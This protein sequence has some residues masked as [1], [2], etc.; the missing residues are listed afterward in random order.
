ME[1]AR[2]YCFEALDIMTR[3]HDKAVFGL[4]AKETGQF[5]DPIRY[6]EHSL[7]LMRRLGNQGGVA[8]AWR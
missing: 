6:Y 5:E 1:P 7:V 2:A 3:T 4:V 8:D